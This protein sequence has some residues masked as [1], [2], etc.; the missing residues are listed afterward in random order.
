MAL[1]ALLAIL[2]TPLAFLHRLLLSLV[3]LVLLLWQWRKLQSTTV[4]QILC[5]EQRWYV[6]LHGKEQRIPVVVQ[7]YSRPFVHGLVLILNPRPLYKPRLRI[8]LGRDNLEPAVFS[9]VCR[10]LLCYTEVWRT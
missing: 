8:Y 9:A 2:F 4:L 10:Q 3:L 1:L 7:N 5:V 6:Q